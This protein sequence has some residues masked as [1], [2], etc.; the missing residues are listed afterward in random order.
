MYQQLLPVVIIM[1]AGYL[2]RRLAPGGIPIDVFSL[3]LNTF[4]FTLCAPTLIFAIVL[5]TDLSQGVAVIPAAGALGILATIFVAIAVYSVVGKASG[6]AKPRQ[7]AL[8]LSCCFANG[9]IALPV[10]DTMFPDIGL[11]V[12]LFYDLLATVPLIWTVGAMIAVRYGSSKATFRD[13]VGAVLRLPPAWAVAAALLCNMAG[14]KLPLPVSAAFHSIGEA[15]IP[16]MVFAVGMA[17]RFE[18]LRQIWVILPSLLIRL[19]IAPLIGVAIA[20]FMG[21]SGPSLAVLAIAMASSAP[22]V[23]VVLAQRYQLDSGIYGAT[24]TL[25]MAGFLILAP[26]YQ[27]WLA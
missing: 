25:S 7:G 11:R 18:R 24:L 22:S 9:G 5:E 1:A 17:I 13:M 21:L 20:S 12:V 6:M 23:G 4:L 3:H 27:V 15:G 19:V 16:L 10:A 8:V 14:V 2:W 26:L